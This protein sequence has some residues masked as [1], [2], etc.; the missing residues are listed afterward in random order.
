MADVSSGLIFLTKE[1][2]RKDT[3]YDFIIL[4]FIETV[5]P[6]ERPTLVSVACAPKESVRSA[7]VG[8]MIL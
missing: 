3:P 8:L 5:W 7:V 1:K 2:K 6:S 4:K